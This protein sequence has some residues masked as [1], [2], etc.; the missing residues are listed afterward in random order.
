MPPGFTEHGA[1]ARFDGVGGRLL[2]LAAEGDMPV[3][4]VRDF[5]YE[6]LPQL[7]WAISPQTDETLV[8]QRGRERLTIAATRENDHLLLSV[9]LVVSQAASD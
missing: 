3:Q 9:Q 7:G 2:I 6:C 5:Y 8:F 1:D 4:A